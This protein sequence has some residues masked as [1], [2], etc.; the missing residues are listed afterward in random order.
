MGTSQV[1]ILVIK[2]MLLK[3][4]LNIKKKPNANEIGLGSVNSS[5]FD[6]ET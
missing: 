6:T 2:F 3:T 4:L 5:L 1:Q